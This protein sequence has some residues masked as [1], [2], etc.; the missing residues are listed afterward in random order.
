MVLFLPP[1]R[2][3]KQSKLLKKHT[4]KVLNYLTQILT[5]DNHILCYGP[6]DMEHA[7]ILSQNKHKET[8]SQLHMTSPHQ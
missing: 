4:Y 6:T 5:H 3:E 1:L 8:C 2:E 7:S